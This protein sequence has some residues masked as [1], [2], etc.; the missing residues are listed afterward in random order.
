MVCENETGKRG[1]CQAGELFRRG[2]S[3]VE[4][5]REAIAPRPLSNRSMPLQIKGGGTEL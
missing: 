3:E 5:G 2:V 1:W 4:E